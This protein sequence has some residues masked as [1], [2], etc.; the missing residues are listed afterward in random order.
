MIKYTNQQNQTGLASLFL[1]VAAIILFVIVLVAVFFIFQGNNKAIPESK[2]EQSVMND[3]KP[4]ADDQVLSPVCE[5]GEIDDCNDSI[6]NADVD[7]LT[8]DDLP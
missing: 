8:V 3:S 1:I 7:A 6:P 5:T 2:N 4:I